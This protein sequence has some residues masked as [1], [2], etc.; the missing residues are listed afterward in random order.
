MIS[1]KLKAPFVFLFL[2]LSIDCT[3]DRRDEILQRYHPSDFVHAILATHC[4]EEGLRQEKSVAEPINTWSPHNV[5]NTTDQFTKDNLVDNILTEWRVVQLYDLQ[6]FSGY[7]GVLYVNHKDKQLVLAHRGSQNVMSYI[8][9]FQGVF[10]GKV[11]EFHRNMRDLTAKIVKFISTSNYYSYAF[12][13]TGHSLGGWLADLSLFYCNQFFHFKNVKAV[14]FEAPGSEYILNHVPIEVSQEIRNMHKI[15]QSGLRDWPNE[16]EVENDLDITCYC[17]YPNLVNSFNKHIGNLY[18][19]IDK[20]FDYFNTNKLT[21]YSMGSKLVYGHSLIPML[22]LFN[23]ITGRPYNARKIIRWPVVD[24][25]KFGNIFIG[26]PIAKQDVYFINDEVSLV[27]MQQDIRKVTDYI[28][29][30]IVNILLKEED[31]FDSSVNKDEIFIRQ[32]IQ[33]DKTCRE[34]QNTVDGVTISDVR[35]RA[36]RIIHKTHTNY[37]K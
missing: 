9:D 16:F 28:D 11:T 25:K 35:D 4:Y 6:A 36:R 7:V 31:H 21:F 8:E 34:L 32:H 24:V 23:P 26:L 20:D 13:I 2:V 29:K 30:I 33:Y 10:T 27:A 14:T 37:S 18:V 12:S 17:M 5:F 19:I 15:A 22:P 3:G 1:L